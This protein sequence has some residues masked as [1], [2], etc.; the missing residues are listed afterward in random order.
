MALANWLR[1]PATPRQI[2][3]W[4]AEVAQHCVA[5]VAARLGPAAGSMSLPEARGYIRARLAA[6]L[7]AEMLL[8]HKQIGCNPKLELAVRCQ[9]TD[10][11]VRM[12]IGDL[13]KT[14]HRHT[15]RKA[16]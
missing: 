1:F 15:L 3:V 16:A 8:L 7:D 13:L 11:I 14:T 12:T 2:A 9:A 10:E 4:A 5:D 6:V